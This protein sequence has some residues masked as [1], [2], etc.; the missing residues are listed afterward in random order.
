MPEDLVKK[1][2]RRFVLHSYFVTMVVR[3]FLVY[4]GLKN[5]SRHTP[6]PSPKLA[7][8]NLHVNHIGNLSSW[9]LFYKKGCF[10]IIWKALLALI[11]LYV[12]MEKGETSHL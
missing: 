4:L 5:V 6:H 3:I 2:R 8:S 9:M 11:D 7:G 10:S 1:S 12:N